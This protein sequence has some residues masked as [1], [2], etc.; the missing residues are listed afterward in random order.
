[1]I[2]WILTDWNVIKVGGALAMFIAFFAVIFANTR[3]SYNEKLYDRCIWVAAIAPLLIIGASMITF[4]ETKTE[5]TYATQW[6]TIY[7]NSQE[8]SPTVSLSLYRDMIFPIMFKIDTS[9]ELGSKY[10]QFQFNETY[11]R[12]YTT[13]DIIANS[14]DSEESRHIIL[15]KEDVIVDGEL[16]QHSKITK[17]E[18]LKIPHSYHTFLGI[19]SNDMKSDFDGKIRI[20][21]SGEKQVEKTSIF[22]D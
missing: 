4:M 20:T 7:D 21:F 10:S 19:R 8:T 2:E 18:Y 17:I 15:H 12:G 13:G 6:K 3:Y 22:G 9:Q 16:S 14:D 1:M 11:T 5:Y